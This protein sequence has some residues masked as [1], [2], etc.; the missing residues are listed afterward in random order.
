M[1][2][3]VSDVFA[4]APFG[5]EPV[6][7]RVLGLVRAWYEQ[8]AGDLYLTRPVLFWVSMVG[9]SLLAALLLWHLAFS[10]I[11]ALRG[12]LHEAPKVALSPREISAVDLRH[13]DISLQRGA[14]REVVERAWHVVAVALCDVGVRHQ[15]PRY[16]AQ[17]LARVLPSSER[18]VVHFLVAA[19]ERACYADVAPDAHEAHE[20]LHAA[21]RLL[22][23]RRDGGGA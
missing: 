11:T 20:V 10:L 18:V 7:G 2:A 12:L 5:K 22:R 1:Q 14:Y 8:D 9:L 13:V 4:V 3:A 21:A 23:W 15:T 17:A 16:Q 6:E 19:H